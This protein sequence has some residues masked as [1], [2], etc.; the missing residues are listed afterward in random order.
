MNRKLLYLIVLLTATMVLSRP[1]P[2]DLT[3]EQTKQAEALI[4]QFTAREFA[5]RQQAVQK[6]IQMGP[7][8]LPLLRKTLAETGDA[9]VKLRSEM[10]VRGLAD[11][12]AGLKLFERRVK[13]L[14]PPAPY[15]TRVVRGANAESMAYVLK[16][17]EKELVVYN[18]KEGPA[19]DAVGPHEALALWGDGRRLAYPARRGAEHF[20]VLDGVEGARYE[21]VGYPHFSRDG[22][23]LAYSARRTKKWLAVYEGKEGQ[24]YDAIPADPQFSPDG[25]HL[26]YAARRGKKWFI[27]FDNKEGKEYDGI[28]DGPQFLSDDTHLTYV[29]RRDGKSFLV[30]DGVEG[31][32]HDSVWVERGTHRVLQEGKPRYLAVDDKQVWVLETDWPHRTSKRLAEKR[33]RPLGKLPPSYEWRRMSAAGEWVVFA[34]KR[35][36]KTVLV[37]NGKELG[38]YEKVKCWGESTDGKHLFGIGK[39]DGKAFVLSDGKEGPAYDRVYELAISPDGKRLAHVARR[40]DQPLVVCDG[41]ESPIYEHCW[42]LI[43]SPD[44]KHFAYV[45]VRGRHEFI[46]CD[47]MEGPG[48]EHVQYPGFS[49]DSRHLCYV[50]CGG[51]KRLG[52]LSV[53]A[54]DWF[55]VCDGKEGPVHKR[56]ERRDRNRAM[57]QPL[58]WSSQLTGKPPYMLTRRNHPDTLSYTVIDENREWLV[59][60]DWP[61]HLDWTNGLRPVER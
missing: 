28:P 16:R 43:F 20:V 27:V 6:L 40:R 1:A 59:E 4:K 44:S 9:E 48:Y 57:V 15:L 42:R 58:G 17:G 60:I 29:A 30:I 49:P 61:K 14:G 25:K 12:L 45:A 22:K 41:K 21:K 5:L 10:V 52:N 46:V 13:N 56:E 55:I 38:T 36:D 37:R 53:P 39:R 23:R 47:G 8:V 54:G 11:Y 2:A 33:V 34:I 18:G 7:D 3:P 51:F 24:A 26:V 50:A 19:Y 31:H 35:D 32:P